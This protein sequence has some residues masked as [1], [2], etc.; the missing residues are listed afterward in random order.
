M[1]GSTVKAPWSLARSA[2]L[3]VAAAAV[4]DVVRAVE[5]RGRVLHPSTTSEARFAQVTQVYLYVT[6]AAVVLF[7]VWFARCRRNADLLSP[8]AARGSVGWAVAGWLIPVLNL[9]VP[10]GLVLDVQRASAPAGAAADRENLLVNVWWA[11]WAGH[12]LVTFVGMN[13]GS[14]T[15]LPLLVAAEALDLL[16]GALAVCVIQ[17]ITVRQAAGFGAGGQVPAP[18]GL[19]HVS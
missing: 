12:A 2:Q 7:L 13:V 9:W 17:R 3:A 18:A 1:S 16:A 5:A 11:A 14:P 8:G 10:R 15:S 4:A 6:T 19:P